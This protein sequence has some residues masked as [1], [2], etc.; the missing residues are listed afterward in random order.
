MDYGWLIIAFIFCIGIMASFGVFDLS[1][2]EEP[3]FSIYKEECRNET[4]YYSEFPIAPKEYSSVGSDYGDEF[5][6][7]GCDDDCNLT[8]VQKLI[9]YNVLKEPFGFY[10][11]YTSRI[12][13][14][15]HLSPTREVCEIVG[16]EEVC[17]DIWGL[18][19]R[20]ICDESIGKCIP[21]EACIK[22]KDITTEW[23]DE[24]CECV[25]DIVYMKYSEYEDKILKCHK[26]SSR[27]CLWIYEGNCWENRFNKCFPYDKGYR[28]N[29]N[30][31]Y[32]TKINC[33]KYRCQEYIVETWGQIK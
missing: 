21:K 28:D 2:Y 30:N 15:V 10:N 16:A 25:N 8:E 7:V 9:T 26:K 17:G 31:F 23:L 27:R 14:R 5:E 12:I 19:L 13:L 33:Q 32:V 11:N 3:H 1:K 18:E 6:V 22:K 29:N 4:G 24:N 20:Y